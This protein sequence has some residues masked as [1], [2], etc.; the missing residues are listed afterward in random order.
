[1]NTSTPRNQ[2]AWDQHWDVQRSQRYHARRT[3]FFDRWHKATA[4]VGLLGG[5]AVIASLGSMAPTWLA[6]AGA[7]LVVVMS[8]VD[9]VVGT[10]EMART[11]ND[12]R[13][14]FCELEADMALTPDP[15][16]EQ[17]ASWRRRRL[18]IE[19]DEP[20]TYVALDVLCHNELAR[21]YSHL[22][23]Q[24]RHSLPLHQ[25]LTAQLFRWQDA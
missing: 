2:A 4:F 13:R 17:V 5:S 7:V 9:L 23:N 20:P 8:A 18:T 16:P 22:A 3:A 11:H 19:A 24:P 1:M 14:R 10:A 12:L 21:S 25:R 15:T 6:T